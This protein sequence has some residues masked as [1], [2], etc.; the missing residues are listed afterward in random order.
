MPE[1]SRHMSDRI[2][3]AATAATGRVRYHVRALPLRLQRYGAGPVPPRYR[4]HR[5]SLHTFWSLYAF[6]PGLTIGV[7][8]RERR[9]PSDRLVVIPPFLPFLHPWNDHSWHAFIHVEVAGLPGGIVRTVFNDIAVIDDPDLRRRYLATL[10][11]ALAGSADDLV[12][13]QEAVAIAGL[14]LAHAFAALPAAE[15]ARLADPHAGWR[16]I[17]P[18]LRLVEERLDRPL[19]LADL[20]GALR[21]GTPHC[22]RL[23]RRHLGQSPMQYVIEQRVLRAARL[24]LESDRDVSDIARACGFPDRSYLSRRFHLLMGLPPA[25][26]R[27]RYGC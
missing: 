7:G 4:E 14:G 1:P 2:L 17:Q 10:H 13:N 27:L 9:L 26:Y 5:A 25:A 12:R 3:M 19:A 24:L 6:G 15:R 18:A 20:A 23:F 21:V 22:A 8:G 11:G 16:S